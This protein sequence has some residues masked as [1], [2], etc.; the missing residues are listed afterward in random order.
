MEGVMTTRAGASEE[1][2]DRARAFV[3]ASLLASYPGDELE[4]LLLGSAPAGATH[5]LAQLLADEGLD[6]VRAS[7]VALFDRGKERASLYETEYGRM[8]GMSKGNDIADIAGFYN[9]FGLAV[10]AE[11]AH[12]MPDHVAVELEF[13][14]VLLL[15][16]HA[17]DAQGNEE[18]R[19]IVDGA[20]R[21]FL[22]DHLGRLAR[23]IADRPDV[24][25]HPVYGPV[26]AWCAELVDAE[27]ASLGVTPAPLDFFND[28][29]LQRGPDCGQVRLPVVQG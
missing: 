18:G 1:L 6:E 29:E 3:V 17:L 4:E 21:S 24:A 5:G 22:A 9:A 2:S 25:A 15:K 27:C 10:D 19:A 13:Y 20:R 11:Q 16:R 14:G 28:E 8:R 26:F 12:E 7:Y 23:A